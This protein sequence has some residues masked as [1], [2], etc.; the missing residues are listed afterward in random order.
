MNTNSVSLALLLWNVG[1]LSSRSL[2]GGVINSTLSFADS[3][4]LRSARLKSRGSAALHPDTF[5]TR[6]HLLSLLVH[7]E[8]FPGQSTGHHHHY[9]RPKSLP[10]T[11]SW[12][13]ALLLLQFI[14]KLHGV[15]YKMSLTL[16][17]EPI[18]DLMIECHHYYPT[19]TWMQTSLNS[20]LYCGTSAQCKEDNHTFDLFNSLSLAG[21]KNF[22]TVSDLII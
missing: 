1:K 14:D 13:Q 5:C 8:I 11:H 7:L 6:D 19:L 2:V 20:C 17:T 21:T 12:M 10:A 22:A 16:S 9:P 18:I 3:P 15:I 4:V